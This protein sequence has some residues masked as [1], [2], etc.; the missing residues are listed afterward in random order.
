MSGHDVMQLFLQSVRSWLPR[1]KQATY[2]SE[3]VIE[4]GQNGSFSVVV[5]WPSSK[6]GPAGERRIYFDRSKVL[7]RSVAAMPL[8][9]RPVKKLCRF[10]DDIIAEVLRA[11]GVR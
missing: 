1:I 11:R 9:Q 7:G 2:A 8:Q 6:A 3:A 5:R 10:R 4:K